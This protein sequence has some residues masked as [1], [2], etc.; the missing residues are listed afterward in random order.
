MCCGLGP[1]TDV[2][3]EPPLIGP[4]YVCI[5]FASMIF[6]CMTLV[7]LHIQTNDLIDYLTSSDHNFR[8]YERG[9]SRY[10]GPGTQEEAHETR[11]GPSHRR[12]ILIFFLL[13][14]SGGRSLY[15]KS[16]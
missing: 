14:F 12:F 15:F 7:I 10:I 13:L 5:L 4:V 6:I 16:R 1:R 8:A 9:F 2:P 11:K 3:A